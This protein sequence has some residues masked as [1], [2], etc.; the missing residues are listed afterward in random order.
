MGLKGQIILIETIVVFNN[1]KLV[2]HL[3][4]SDK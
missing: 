3:W 1:M 2:V 4:A